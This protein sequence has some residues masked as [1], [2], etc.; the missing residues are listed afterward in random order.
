MVARAGLPTPDWAQA[1]DWNGLSPGLWIV[2]SAEEDASFGLD[3]G[4]V[5]DAGDVPARAAHCAARYGGAWFAERFIEGRE[6]NLSVLEENGEA[7]VLPVAEIAFEHWDE[8]R[9]K[10]VS[11]AAKWDEQAD[12]YRGT[13]RRFT[14]E[15]LLEAELSRLA[16]ACFRLF[17][18]RGYARIDFRVDAQNRPFIL[19]TNANPC[20]APDAG[21]AAAAARAGIAYPDLIEKVLYDAR[22][23]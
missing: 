2:K 9:P 6:F 17:G 20:L 18:L 12:E 13:V 11:Y 14:R 1:P 7:H 19:E 5:V 15:P 10:I 16:L 23:A 8:S 21:F 22:T 4:A 3:D